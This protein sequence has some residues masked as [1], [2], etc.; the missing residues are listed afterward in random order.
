MNTTLLI[1][2]YIMSAFY[3]FA[4]ISHFRKPDFFLKIIPK[5]VPSP[6]KVNF[7]VGGI[8]IVLGIGLLF[9]DIR[10]YAAWGIIALL[11]AVFPA[12]IYHYQQARKKGKHVIATLIRLPIQG[13][14]IYW[15]Y[16]F[17]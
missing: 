11:V 3:L 8:E 15:A 5:W 14:L 17:I 10:A 16:L 9:A 2:L 12:N 7:L 6:K 4:G 1:S 13:V